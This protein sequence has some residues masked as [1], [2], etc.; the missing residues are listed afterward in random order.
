MGVAM[1]IADHRSSSCW[2]RKT[3]MHLY[4]TDCV[5]LLAFR[6]WPLRSRPLLLLY[7]HH[8]HHI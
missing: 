3:D 2:H 1:I 7:H 8:H 6:I 4:S 5:S